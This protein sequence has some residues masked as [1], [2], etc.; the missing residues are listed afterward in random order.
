[1]YKD[2]EPYKLYETMDILL[3]YEDLSEMLRKAV[4]EIARKEKDLTKDI[5]EKGIRLEHF[6]HHRTSNHVLLTTKIELYEKYLRSYHIY[7]MSFLSNLLER[8]QLLFRQTEP[9]TDPKVYP[10]EPMN[11]YLPADATEASTQTDEVLVERDEAMPEATPHGGP[12]VIS[13]VVS[14]EVTTVAA[15][16]EV[17]S[18]SVMPEAV[19]TEVVTT[20]VVTSEAVKPDSEPVSETKE[21]PEDLDIVLESSK[22]SESNESK[23]S[24]ESNE[25]SSVPA[26]LMSEHIEH[27][28][29][30]I[31][32]T[33][34]I[35]S[36]E[37]STENPI[38]E[39]S[40]ELSLEPS[41][42][43]SK[44]KKKKFKK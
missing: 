41:L 22:S 13:E 1:M 24:N 8:L 36:L 18:E 7:H 42:E 33:N 32:P 15:M 43:P 5:Q 29:E 4:H 38:L 2:L 28:L 6:I 21:D 34:Q 3:L 31:Q 25:S 27:L 10:P 20:E 16:P 40:L 26:E 14:P 35:E 30:T 37:H 39:P 19:T 12:E 17:T 11:K 23:E 44:K 9:P